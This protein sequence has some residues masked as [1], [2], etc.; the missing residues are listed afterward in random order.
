MAG[1]SQSS[2]PQRLR[3]VDLADSQVEGLTLFEA[4]RKGK[5]RVAPLDDDTQTI[6]WS[7]RES[8]TAYTVTRKIS[9][10]RGTV[11]TVYTCSCPDAKKYMRRDCEHQFAEKLRRG[12]VVITGRV[13]VN[14]PRKD[15]AGRRPAR[16]RL[17]EDG[18]SIKSAQRDARVKMPGEI[19][20][21]V[22]SLKDAYD[23][24]HPGALAIRR[25][26]LTADS[27]RAAALLLKVSEG[28]SADAMV[29]RYQQL[30]EDGQCFQ[31]F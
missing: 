10:V 20:R 11:K 5:A 26:K 31:V 13:P 16:K 14:R 4:C 22:L 18:R 8:D 17:A 15:K 24:R 28:K 19:P 21:L 30:I 7:S 27:L 12:E 25:G 29:S 2:E 9:N 6:Y 1:T 3:A 23:A